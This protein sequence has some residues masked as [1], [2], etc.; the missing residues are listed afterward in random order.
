MNDNHKKTSATA[1]PSN[2]LIIWKIERR[3][4]IDGGE[5]AVV[6]RMCGHIAGVADIKSASLE[7]PLLPCLECIEEKR[8][9]RIRNEKL[10]KKHGQ[11]A[12]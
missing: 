1:H 5:V 9:Q 8:K 2:D 7:T 11:M 10:A 12:P 4:S 3:A 6:T